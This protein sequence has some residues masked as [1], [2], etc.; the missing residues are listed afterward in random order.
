MSGRRAKAQRKAEREGMIEQLLLGHDFEMLDTWQ[1]PLSGEVYFA[2]KESEKIFPVVPEPEKEYP[3]DTRPVCTS[4]G[5][6]QNETHYIP[7]MKAGGGGFFTCD[8]EAVG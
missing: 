7:I 4:C 8:M 1:D 6:R 2:P 5:K 3:N